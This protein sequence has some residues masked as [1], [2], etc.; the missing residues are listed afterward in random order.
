[1]LMYFMHK[2]PINENLFSTI[3]TFTLYLVFA[4]V[5]ALKI[6]KVHCSVTHVKPDHSLYKYK[7]FK[8]N[9]KF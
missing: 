6:S 1:M 2:T 9:Q 4:L 8:R 7:S 3:F 5:F